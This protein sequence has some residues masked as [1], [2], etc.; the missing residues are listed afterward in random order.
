MARGAIAELIITLKDKVSKGLGNIGG[1][2][3]KL[4]RNVEKSKFIWAGLAGGIAAA[5]TMFVSAASK[6]EGW[7]ISFETMLGSAD[8]A[9]SLMNDVRKFA[10]QTPFELTEVIKGTKG[11]LAF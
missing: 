9:K 3:D 1:R 11:L 2:L 6:M 8:K 7:Q 4:A 5:G 10:A